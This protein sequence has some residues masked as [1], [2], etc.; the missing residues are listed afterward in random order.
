MAKIKW[1]EMSNNEYI[2]IVKDRVFKLKLGD[3]GVMG[4]GKAYYLSTK[5]KTESELFQ[6]TV[7]LF[8]VIIVD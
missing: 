7:L 3:R 4:Y 6:F 5:L 8:Q 1:E 2:T